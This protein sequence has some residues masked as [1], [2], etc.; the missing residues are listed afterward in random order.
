M[1]QASRLPINEDTVPKGFSFRELS[2][3]DEVFIMKSQ[4]H[5]EKS[6]AD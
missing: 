4:H 1:F 5:N 3:P 2:P 6:E